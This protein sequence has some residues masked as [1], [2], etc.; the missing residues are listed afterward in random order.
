MR[1]TVS[2]LNS[3]YPPVG[4]Y[5]PPL[6]PSAAVTWMSPEAY[7]VSGVMVQVVCT[8]PGPAPPANHTCP[9]SSRQGTPPTGRET[10]RVRHLMTRFG[11][12]VTVTVTVLVCVTVCTVA[13][14]TR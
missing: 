14:R 11:V 13:G 3:S 10:A 6:V 1:W 12:L 9:L 4:A 7:G 8:M 5:V 2:T